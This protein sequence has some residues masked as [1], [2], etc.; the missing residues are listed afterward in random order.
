MSARPLCALI[1]DKGLRF[2]SSQERTFSAAIPAKENEDD[3]L[4]I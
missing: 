2:L 1:H 4:A 3:L